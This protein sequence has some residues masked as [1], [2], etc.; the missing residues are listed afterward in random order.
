MHITYSNAHTDFNG[1]SAHTLRTFE[2]HG[3][4][5]EA[6]QKCGQWNPSNLIFLSAQLP[7]TAASHTKLK[8]TMSTHTGISPLGWGDWTT[9]KRNVHGTHSQHW[10]LRLVF[11]SLTNRERLPRAPQAQV[12][13]CVLLHV[14]AH[15]H[16]HT[17][18]RTHTYTH[19]HTHTVCM[20]LTARER[21]PAWV[22]HTLRA[23]VLSICCWWFA[24]LRC[25]VPG[26]GDG[27]LQN[28]STWCWTWL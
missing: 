4:E 27:S 26:M 20:G 15:T 6:R 17:H 8:C 23:I 1:L 19:T 25:P 5:Y 13:H 24:L 14:R 16:T 18:T 11:M 10:Q 12:L 9:N 3:F 7:Q 21:L 22:H 28:K 2:Q